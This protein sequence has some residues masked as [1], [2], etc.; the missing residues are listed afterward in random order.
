LLCALQLALPALTQTQANPPGA[1][2][3][4]PID[5][6]ANEQE[7]A[8]DTVLINGN[9]KV[10]YKD[11]T[12]YSPQATLIRTPDGQPKL[13]I[14]KG[15]P[16]LVQGAN[17]MDADTLEFEIATGQIIADGHSHSEVASEGDDDKKDD[18]KDDSKDKI[19]TKSDDTADKSK[20]GGTGSDDTADKSK[21]GGTGSDDTADKS[22]DGGTGSDD[23][24]DK[25]KNG[26]TGSDTTIA[27][28]SSTAASKSKQKVQK[29]MKG[30]APKMI[31]TD[32]DHLEYV[33]AGGKFEAQGHVYMKTGDIVVHSD[34]VQ[35]MYGADNRPEAAIFA[36]NVSATRFDNNTLAD[37]MTYFL[38]TQKLQAT[39]NVRSKV[40]QKNN[41][42]KGG[43]ANG[44]K[45]TEQT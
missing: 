7:F 32:A 22:K 41:P 26:G 17:K 6:Q 20:N 11:C 40:I 12:I 39:G 24:A 33:Q 44:L 21:G 43:P 36:G 13:A 15:H 4:S 16:H 28:A 9:V 30:T 14:F 1:G 38:S 35:L 37:N 19:S 34:K 10:M 29:S 3:D 42:K 27:V 45:T 25:S 8:G 18:K 31:I 5:I 2:G 23:T